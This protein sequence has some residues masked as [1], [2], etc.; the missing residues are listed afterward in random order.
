[1]FSQVSVCPQGGMSVPLHAGIHTSLGKTPLGRHTP[2]GSHPPVQD[3]YHPPTAMA[4]SP[5]MH[6]T[7]PCIPP[8]THILLPCMP[9]PHTPPPHTPL[10]HACPSAT[11]ALL[12]CMPPSPAMHAPL[13]HA[14]PH[15]ACPCNAH[16]PPRM[17]P[18]THAPLAVNRITDACENITLLQLCCGSNNHPL[19][20]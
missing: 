13:C 8:A 4:I 16:P 5:A 10:C 20:K 9:L 1:M 15:H 2:L 12:P 6:T 11:Y 7:L 14:C 17:L 18:T 19:P 3:A